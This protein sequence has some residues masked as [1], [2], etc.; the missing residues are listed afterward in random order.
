MNYNA[1][2]VGNETLVWKINHVG[3]ATPG[4][5]A[6]QSSAILELAKVLSSFA[7]LDNPGGRLSPRGCRFRQ[8]RYANRCGR[9]GAAGRVRHC[10]RWQLPPGWLRP[11]PP[12]R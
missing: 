3:T 5:P 12:G 8:T 11:A 4:C 1:V 2:R 6:E 9:P 10:R 7:R